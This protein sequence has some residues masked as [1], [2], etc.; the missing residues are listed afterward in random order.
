MMAFPSLQA[1]RK[2]KSEG[3]LIILHR[4]NHFKRRDI[5]LEHLLVVQIFHLVCTFHFT[6]FCAKIATTNVLISFAWLNRRLDA[7]YAFSF[8][9]SIAAITV[10]YLPVTAMQLHRKSVVIFQGDAVRKHEFR[11][12]RITVIRLVK[13][14]NTHLY[15]F[16]NE[17]V[18]TNQFT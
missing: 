8:H 17:T 11:L 18:H 10:E 6:H 3:F 1:R 16:R 14:F 12:D 7:Y 5:N 15:P 4:N 13:C 2:G 9:F